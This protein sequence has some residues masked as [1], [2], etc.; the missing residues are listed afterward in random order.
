MIQAGILNG[1][2]CDIRYFFA[3]RQH[4][5]S[6]AIKAIM[7]STDGCQLD[8]VTRISVCK[9]NYEMYLDKFT[10]RTR[11]W[12]LALFKIQFSRFKDI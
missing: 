2:A 11:K 4:G 9:Q 1:E 7:F 12:Q 8:D 5:D 6:V 3:E 10:A